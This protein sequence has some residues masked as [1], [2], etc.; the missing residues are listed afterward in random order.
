M[1]REKRNPI[2]HPDCGRHRIPGATGGFGN[3]V[4]SMQVQTPQGN[5]RMPGVQQPGR[6]RDC[7]V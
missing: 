1:G 6:K 4:H 3:Q 5:T 2:R 7:P